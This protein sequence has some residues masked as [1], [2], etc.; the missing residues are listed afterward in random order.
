MD[1]KTKLVYMG[2]GGVVALAGLSSIYPQVSPYVTATP[3]LVASLILFMSMG[4][5]QLTDKKLDINDVTTAIVGIL[6]IT[7]LGVGFS[8]ATNFVLPQ[9]LL[10][11]STFATIV[12]G[13]YVIVLG[14]MKK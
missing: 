9:F 12:I 2:L 11:L 7:V 6:G 14:L 13:I 8:I 5:K 10:T 1:W 3:Y 4:W